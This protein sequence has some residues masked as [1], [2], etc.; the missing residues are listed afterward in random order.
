[1]YFKPKSPSSRSSGF[2][3][4]ELLVVLAIIALMTSLLSPA[5]S[6]IFQSQNF[7]GNVDEV[8]SL[9]KQAR[10][11]AMAQNTF[12]WLGFATSTNNGSPLLTI[13]AVAG[14]SGL[15]TD[16]PNNITPEMKPLVLRNLRLV[17]SASLSFN[18]NLNNSNTY[19]TTNNTDISQ[20]AITFTQ[21]VAGQSTPFSS[22]IVFTPDGEATL[23]T[24]KTYPCIG[25]GLKAG[26]TAAVNAQV[27]AIQIAGLSAEPTLFRQ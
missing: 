6:S 13:T 7:G 5:F 26:P 14:T 23:D 1:M 27:A 19:N 9:I 16:L 24:T 11:Q 8:N 18:A 15:S 10:A 2:S 3:L 17:T 22:V 12:V 21:S 4:V 25:I 20:S